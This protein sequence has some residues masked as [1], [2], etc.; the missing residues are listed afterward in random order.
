M[1]TSSKKEKDVIT[2]V[3]QQSMI[4]SSWNWFSCEKVAEEKKSMVIK[5]LRC[6][7]SS[8]S[9]CIFIFPNVLACNN[10]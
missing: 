5:N 8:K 3:K 6:E 9:S 1:I 4:C 7:R 10:E 2:L